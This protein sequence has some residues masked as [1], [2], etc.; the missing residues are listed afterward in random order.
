MAHV[1]KADLLGFASF[2]FP[3]HR[4]K[5]FLWYCY[6]LNSI[7]MYALVKWKNYMLWFG[8]WF[9]LCFGLVLGFFCLFLGFCV[10]FF[11]FILANLVVWFLI[12]VWII[13]KSL[14]STDLFW[15]ISGF[16][17][18]SMKVLIFTWLTKLYLLSKWN[19]SSAIVFR[20]SFLPLYYNNIR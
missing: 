3:L 14:F 4:W 20:I 18:C 19:L 8:C 11:F 5:F 6:F 16:K 13:D 7:C 12:R 17:F 15:L 9:L 10:F 2:K 1:L